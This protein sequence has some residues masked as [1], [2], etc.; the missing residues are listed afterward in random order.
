MRSRYPA[1]QGSVDSTLAMKEEGRRRSV[2]TAA[3]CGVLIAFTTGLVIALDIVLSFGGGSV[4]R[5]L[6]PGLSYLSF[7][8][9][10]LIPVLAVLGLVAFG[11]CRLLGSKIV[12]AVATLLL[13]FSVGH[14]LRSTQAGAQLE[15]VSG[16]DGIPAIEFSRFERLPSFSDGTAYVWESRCS[17]DDARRMVE[18]LQLHAIPREDASVQ[19]YEAYF[20]DDDSGTIFYED[21]RGIVAGFNPDHGILRLVSWPAAINRDQEG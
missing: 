12:C 17:E 15:R 2:K 3:W 8:G 18:S 7:Y 6:D 4:G 10:V 1:S 9:I 19:C 20:G 16:H 21:G 13:L 5:G 14:S 11:L